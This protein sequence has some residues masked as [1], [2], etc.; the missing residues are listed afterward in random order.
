MTAGSREDRSQCR[1]PEPARVSTRVE[2]DVERLSGRISS[3]KNAFLI[4]LVLAIGEIL[5]GVAGAGGAEPSLEGYGTDSTFGGGPGS[6]TCVVLH[7]ADSGVGSLRDCVENRNGP[8]DNPIPR[9]VVF[10]TGGTI[11]LLADLSI[12][13]PYLTIDGLTA[14][15]PGITLAKEGTG[16]IG[17]TNIVT[18]QGQN[19][20]AHDVLVQ[21]LRFRGVWTR[22]TNEHSQNADMLSVDGE[23]LPG[24]LQNVVIWRNTYIDGQDS[25]GSLWGSVRDLTFAYNFVV[26]N[27]HPQTISH[28]P[29]GEQGQQRERLSIHHNVF[30]YNHERTAN[31]RANVWDVNFEQNVIHE[32]DPFGLPGGYATRFRCRNGGCPLRFNMLDNHWTSAGGSLSQAIN[33]QS[34]ADPDQVF[35]QGNTKP[36]AESE[37][38]AA[39]GPF[40]RTDSVTVFPPTTLGET[41]FP[42]V[43]HP[44]PTQE[45]SDVLA[46][47]LMQVETEQGP[48][49]ADGFES[50]NTSAWS[51]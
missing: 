4:V 40:P 17:E 49:F 41:M 25:V 16:E 9:R 19:T 18:W 44:Y 7:T 10:S 14:P 6:E 47:V 51:N 2:P 23:N 28:Y 12:R 3:A 34:D 36:D 45:E 31:F 32:W 20:C 1:H 24:C 43:G 26:F 48:L 46:E 27:Y 5:G 37:D 39:N 38:G 50:G 11:V 22:D 13:Q 8:L 29:G 33:F 15:A 21:G 42:Y 30:A 35:S